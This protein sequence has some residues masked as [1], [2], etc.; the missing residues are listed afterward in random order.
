MK[1]TL[2]A[3]L[4]VAALFTACGDD[5]D[6]AATDEPVIDPGDGGRYE[7]VIDPADFVAEIDNPYMPF[8]VGTTWVYEGDGERVEVTVLD[9]RREI[10]GVSTVVVRDT[11]TVDG[12]LVEDT[13]D[14]FAQDA[15]GNV[16]YFGEE[17]QNFAD[18][19]LEDTDGSWEAGVDGALPGIAMPADPEVGDAYRQEFWE[20]EAE[21]LGEIVRTGE[22]VDVPFGPMD[23]VVVTKDWNP[24][25]PEVI[26]EKHY[27]RGVGLVLEEH[28]R[29]EP[30]RVELVEFRAG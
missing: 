27:A 20:G 21:D 6:V 13:L 22:T 14:W 7:P 3:L 23:D 29:G 5:D 24:L 19:K 26:E 17:V 4:A 8:A 16:W 11:V 2:P 12:E 28:V 10:I 30:G 9:E 18:G 15:D 1:R 25:D